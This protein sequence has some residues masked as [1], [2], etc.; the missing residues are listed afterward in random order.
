MTAAVKRD[1]RSP[2]PRALGMRP[3]SPVKDYRQQRFV[4]LALLRAHQDYALPGCKLAH[5]KRRRPARK[6]VKPHR[7]MRA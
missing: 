6:I 1:V 7:R 5:N 3:L 4:G 2:T